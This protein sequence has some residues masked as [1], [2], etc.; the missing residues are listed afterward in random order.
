ML[1]VRLAGQDLANLATHGPVTVEYGPHGPETA[2]W[3]MEPNYQHPLLRASQQVKVYDGGFCIWVGTL[4]QPG[5]SGDYE[6]LGAWHQAESALALDAGGNP[7]TVPDAA[8]AGAYARGEITWS[9]TISSS[10]WGGTSPDP[11]LTLESL[12]DGF[13]AEQGIRWS[14]TPGLTVTTKVD[15]TTP[16]WVVPHT[17]AGRG[18]TPADDEFCTHLVGTY[19]V[20]A[21]TYATRTIGSAAAA[22]VFGRRTRWVDLTPMGVITAAGADSVLTGMFLLSGARM[23]WAEGLELSSTQITTPGD[24]PAPL[25]QITSLQM[26][27]LAGTIDTSRANAMPAYTDIVLGT[28]RYTDGEDSISVTPIGYA[29]RNLGDLLTKAAAVAATTSGQEISA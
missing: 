23:G 28:T 20:T 16:Q 2:S 9:G 7:T 17:V 8:I 11:T 14:V 13:A 24:T 27:R 26:V 15:P 19:L 18:L 21:T 6:A 3:Q 25:A 1:T 4:V 12:L 10:V 5:S 22:N 29:P